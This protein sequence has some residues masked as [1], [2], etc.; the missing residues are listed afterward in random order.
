ME[1][2]PNFHHAYKHLL[3]KVQSSTETISEEISELYPLDDVSLGVCIEF[4]IAKDAVAEYKELNLDLQ[5]HES[6]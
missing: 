6:I 1:E 3:E 2:E 5:S 4:N